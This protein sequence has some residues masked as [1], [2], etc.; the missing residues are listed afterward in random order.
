MRFYSVNKS[1]IVDDGG[2]AVQQVGRHHAKTLKWSL[3]LK[4][5]DYARTSI[6][7][8]SLVV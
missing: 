3:G 6:S 2:E 4:T 5:S 8:L 1:T 7:S